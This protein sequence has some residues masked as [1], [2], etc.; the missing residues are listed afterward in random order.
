M[1][2]YVVIIK[3]LIN[4]INLAKNFEDLDNLLVCWEKEMDK[5]SYTSVPALLH[6]EKIKMREMREFA[7]SQQDRRCE[8]YSK[9]IEEGICIALDF[10]GTNIVKNLLVVNN[11]L[12]TI[13]SAKENN[14]WAAVK[15]SIKIFE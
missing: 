9:G 8:N 7:I 11:L 14:D 4:N 3:I 1:N 5:K 13:K 10:L 6:R 15:E 12:K 2:K